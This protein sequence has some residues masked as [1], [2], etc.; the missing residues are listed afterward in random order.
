MNIKIEHLNNP[1]ELGNIS[2][3]VLVA[4]TCPSCNKNEVLNLNE[5]KSIPAINREFKIR[6]SHKDND[7]CNHQW[8]VNLVAR[9][10]VFEVLP[11]K[12]LGWST[13]DTKFQIIKAYRGMTGASLLDAK[14]WS[15][16]GPH[17]IKKEMAEILELHG[18]IIVWNNK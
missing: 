3:A 9:L 7:I 1:V 12:Y 14:K 5:S 11:A 8:D 16:T 18:A 6:F 13:P 4:S 15:E 17:K 2:A 10:A